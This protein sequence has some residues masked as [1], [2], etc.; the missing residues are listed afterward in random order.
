MPA[1][2]DLGN[3]HL[4]RRHGGLLAI[5]TLVDED[6]RALVLLPALR[7]NAAWF[8]VGES[9][10]YR[11]DDPGYLALQAMFACSV[12]GIEPTAGNALRVATIVHEGLPDLIR[13]PGAPLAPLGAALG[14]VTLRVDGKPL[15]GATLYA[16]CPPRTR[17]RGIACSAQATA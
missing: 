10:A 8:I 12:L 17:W 11:Y 2:L 4:T 13:M 16:F 14:E 9:A 3:A 15:S 7:R 6:E 5:Y 1:T